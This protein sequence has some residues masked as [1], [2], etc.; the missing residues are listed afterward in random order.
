MLYLELNPTLKK[1]LLKHI[2]L[3]DME[4]GTMKIII[5]KENL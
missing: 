3:I 2:K 1:I 4:G 5:P